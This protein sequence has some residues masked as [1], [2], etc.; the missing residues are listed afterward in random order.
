MLK[1][2]CQDCGSPTS[3]ISLK[4]K[5][6][7]SCGKPFD[8][9]LVVN[10][11]QLQKQTIIEKPRIKAKIQNNTEED[12]NNDDETD[13]INYVPDISGIEVEISDTK[14]FKVKM[15]DIIGNRE[16]SSKN[17]QEKPSKNTQ[18]KPI[19]EPKKLKKNLPKEHKVKNPDFIKQF[20]SE[21]STLRSSAKNR[22]STDG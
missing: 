18:E 11:I 6:C 12:Y 9:T 2:Y 4:P 20:K 17:T 1:M 16:S 7:T 10:Q 5:F 19:K 15:S 14:P 13:D 3:Y 8:K 22:K 21:A